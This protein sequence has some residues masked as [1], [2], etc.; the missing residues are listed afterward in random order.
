MDFGGFEERTGLEL[1]E[2]VCRNLENI[3]KLGKV[4]KIGIELGKVRK[5][6]IELRL[7]YHEVSE[8]GPNSI[9]THF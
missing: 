4:R 9:L 3:E 2:R 1:E 7:S 6:T 8:F 5:V